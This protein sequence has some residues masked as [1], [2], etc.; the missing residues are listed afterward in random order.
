[1]LDGLAAIRDPTAAL[2]AFWMGQLGADFR[3]GSGATH[4]A[5]AKWRSQIAER[6]WFNHLLSKEM[7]AREMA[8]FVQEE[9]GIHKGMVALALADSNPKGARRIQP[10]VTGDSSALPGGAHF[11]SVELSAA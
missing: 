7:G 4:P 2:K 9:S 8:A 11:G 6:G 1:M 5:C 10:E 3:A